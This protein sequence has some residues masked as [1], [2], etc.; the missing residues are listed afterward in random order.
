MDLEIS[1][2]V[3]RKRQ[4]QASVDRLAKPRHD[5]AAKNLLE[6]KEKEKSEKR[7]SKQI[8]D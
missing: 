8:L 7:K 2:F 6:W 3:R 1:T 4:I 5:Y